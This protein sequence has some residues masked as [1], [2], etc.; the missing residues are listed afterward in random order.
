MAQY[1]TAPNTS[2]EP[3]LMMI[4]SGGRGKIFFK[5]GGE[6]FPGRNL[7]AWAVECVRGAVGALG[8]AKMAKFCP[9]EMFP[10]EILPARHYPPCPPPL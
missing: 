2:P 3:N 5:E 9:S 10:G 8:F 1:S 7:R 4:I 6:I